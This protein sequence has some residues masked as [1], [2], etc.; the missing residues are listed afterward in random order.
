MSKKGR[1]V[2]K[3]AVKRNDTK[4]A[5]QQGDQV[6]RKALDAMKAEEAEIAATADGAAKDSKP[7]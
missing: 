6:V 5:R 4:K 1:A 3:R 2:A 7:N